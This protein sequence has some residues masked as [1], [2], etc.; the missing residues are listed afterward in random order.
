MVPGV[1]RMDDAAR[2]VA[3][4]STDRD[5]KPK[6]QDKSNVVEFPKSKSGSE[7]ER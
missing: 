7:L 3:A 4:A 2:E 6:G 5:E 1:P